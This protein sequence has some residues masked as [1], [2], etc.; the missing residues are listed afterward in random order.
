MEHF[1]SSF[2]LLMQLYQESFWLKFSTEPLNFDTIIRWNILTQVFEWTFLL[3]MQLFDGTFWPR[4]ST[5]LLDFWSNYT[6]NHFDSSFRWK[7][8]TYDSTIKWNISTQFWVIHESY[9]SFW[10]RL[11]DWA[12]DGWTGLHVQSFRVIT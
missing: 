2:Q 6:I 8:S 1:D 10:P 4:F 9:S 11:M 3:L 12:P 7:I 5:E